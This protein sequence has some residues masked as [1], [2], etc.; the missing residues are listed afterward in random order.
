MNSI[1]CNAILG[2]DPPRVYRGELPRVREDF[3]QDHRAARN[4]VTQKDARRAYVFTLEQRSSKYTRRR[5][6][7][8]GWLAFRGRKLHVTREE[9]LARDPCPAE[10]YPANILDVHYHVSPCRGIN[11]TWKRCRT[12]VSRKGKEVGDSD[13][14]VGDGVSWKGLAD[15]PC[16]PTKLGLSISRH[17]AFT[18]QISEVNPGER[19]GRGPDA[20]GRGL[21]PPMNATRFE[22]SSL[23]FRTSNGQNV[24][25][26]GG[27][28]SRR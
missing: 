22:P 5:K 2:K 17:D 10:S 12:N 3:P 13:V 20:S 11:I 7:A 15:R 26:S 9:S 27:R 23:S 18:I 16:P 24:T 25:R 4:F 1:T 8:R 6:V 19:F 14:L 21:Q 28:R